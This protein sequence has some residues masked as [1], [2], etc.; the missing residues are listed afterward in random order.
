MHAVKL[1]FKD[2]VATNFKTRILL[3]FLAESSNSRLTE[4]SQ[5]FLSIFKYVNSWTNLILFISLEIKLL[6]SGKGDLKDHLCN[7]LK[8]YDYLLIENHLCH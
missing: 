1:Q 3:L 2:S 7:L 4:Y 8:S 5:R 6:N